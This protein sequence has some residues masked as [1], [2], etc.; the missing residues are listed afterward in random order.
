MATGSR[1]ISEIMTTISKATLAPRDGRGFALALFGFTLSRYLENRKQWVQKIMRLMSYTTMINKQKSI[2]L[3][4]LQLK[5]KMVPIPSRRAC[6]SYG[7][8]RVV[9][10]TMFR[11][12]SLRLYLG[13]KI[14]E[15]ALATV[16]HL[17]EDVGF[18]LLRL[19]DATKSTCVGII[20]GV[21]LEHHIGERILGIKLSEIDLLHEGS[22]SDVLSRR[23][24][25]EA[26]CKE[27]EGDRK[28]SG[29]AGHLLNGKWIEIL[30]YRWQM[31]LG[32]LDEP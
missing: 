10:V 7:E 9:F 15:H 29:T 12:L 24:S 4:Y 18:L 20:G 11:V 27:K 14:F 1:S 8:C 6:S 32:S 21:D 28:E 25:A 3:S 13:S 2:G 23:C 19:L 26:D 5:G 16:G 22:R 17:V 30:Q 31:S